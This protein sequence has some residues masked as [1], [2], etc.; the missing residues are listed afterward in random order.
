MKQPNSE[1]P[2][3]IQRAH[4]A[5]SKN[6][7]LLAPETREREQTDSSC[8]FT[9]LGTNADA[10]GTRGADRRSMQ[11]CRGERRPLP[12]MALNTNHP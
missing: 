3:L 11:C 4:V 7:Q 12:C 6:T 10:A 5:P 2:G 1:L 8:T 9:R